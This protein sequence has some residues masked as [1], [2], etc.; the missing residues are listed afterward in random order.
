MDMPHSRMPFLFYLYFCKFTKIF[1]VGKSLAVYYS[2]QRVFLL[3]QHSFSTVSHTYFRC[4]THSFQ[5]CHTLIS[6]VPHT[7][8]RC[9]THLF[10]MHATL[11]YAVPPIHFCSAKLSPTMHRA[12]RFPHTQ[13]VFYTRIPQQRC[14]TGSHN[15]FIKIKMSNFAY[16]ISKVQMAQQETP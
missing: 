2:Q 10:Q 12:R 16:K 11:F 3:P 6:D 14:F 5:M 13:Q 9:A 7:H 4:A 8:F 15:L 1:R